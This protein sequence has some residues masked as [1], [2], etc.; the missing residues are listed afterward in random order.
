VPSWSLPEYL[1]SADVGAHPLPDTCLNHRLALPN[2]L[3]DYAFAGLPTVANDLPE[4]AGLLNDRRMGSVCDTTSPADI[5]RA[6]RVARDLDVSF[7]TIEDLSW[8]RQER[9]LLSLYDRLP[10]HW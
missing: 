10:A 7:E 2:K 9:Q 3:F 6:L 1:S 8:E 5:A 4:M